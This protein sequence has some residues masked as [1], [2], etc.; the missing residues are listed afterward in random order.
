MQDVFLHCRADPPHRVGREAETAIGVEAL[1]RLHHAD[2][3]LGDEFRQRQAIAAIAHRN[4]GDEA[5]MAGH[6]LL[7]RIG[8]A[9]LAPTLGQHVLL[10]RLEHGELANLLKIPRQV[11]FGRDGRQCR[12]GRHSGRLLSECDHES[13]RKSGACPDYRDSRKPINCCIS[14][15]KTLS[16]RIGSP[17]AGCEN[18]ITL[19][20]SA[21][22][23]KAAMPARADSGTAANCRWPARA[24]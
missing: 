20:C 10:A 11:P 1:H 21:W 15:G 19:A 23:V 3:A 12:G 14:Q 9:M 24:P 17:V 2:I 16:R 18:P 8:V 6:E 5:Q 22:R 13:N 7:R 4:L